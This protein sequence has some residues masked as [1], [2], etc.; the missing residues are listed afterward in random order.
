MLRNACKHSRRAFQLHCQLTC[1]DRRRWT[2]EHESAASGVFLSAEADDYLFRRMHGLLLM[3][4]SGG[5]VPLETGASLT[6]DLRSLRR[7]IHSAITFLV[8]V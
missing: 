6:S 4:E 3:D 2:V 7:T 5:Q 8:R 1:I